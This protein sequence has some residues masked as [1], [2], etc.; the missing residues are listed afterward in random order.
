MSQILRIPV[1][2]QAYFD[3]IYDGI[4]NK[5]DI[6]NF[7]YQEVIPTPDVYGGISSAESSGVG[8]GEMIFNFPFNELAS[9]FIDTIANYQLAYSDNGNPAQYGN[10]ITEVG[11]LN[12]CANSFFIKPASPLSG[13]TNSVYGEF[14]DSPFNT[15]QLT[16]AF[17]VWP[18]LKYPNPTWQYSPSLFNLKFG[19]QQYLGVGVDYNS[20]SL[21]VYLR[22]NNYPLVADIDLIYSGVIKG[23]WSFIVLWIDQSLSYPTLNIQINNGTVYTLTNIY[24]YDIDIS[25]PHT[26]TVGGFNASNSTNY[27]LWYLDQLTAWSR[28]ITQEE[29]TWLFYDGKGREL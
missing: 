26:L 2:H 29:R 16:L 6:H 22:S 10:L 19:V 23:I 17:W 28:V 12:R 3:T 1:N 14:L 21:H 27:I 24:G 7:L 20:N 5:F 13:M 18:G 11:K 25:T 9:P 8:A 4:D 15:K